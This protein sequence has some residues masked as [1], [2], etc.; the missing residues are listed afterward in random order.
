[1]IEV[2]ELSY[3]YSKAKTNTIDNLCFEV[4]KGEIFGFLGPSGSGKSTTQKILTG[5]MDNYEGSVLVNG[6]EIKKRKRFFY[7]NIG[8]SY[9][10]PNVY[11][12]LTGIENLQFVRHFYKNATQDPLELL[13]MVG[14]EEYAYRKV[15]QYS[16]G[17]KMRLN[18]ARAFINDPDLLFFDE[19][20]SGLDPNNSR[21]VKDIILQSKEK[22][23]TV[24]LTTHNMNIAEE[25]C[26]R[27]AFI[28]DGKI[29]LIDNPRQL[30]V[31]YGERKVIIEY[32]KANELNVREFDMEGLGRNKEFMDFI[33]SESQ[34]VTI[35]SKDASL[36]DVF[37]RV[38]GRKLT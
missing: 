30:K 5:I 15:S 12:K 28:V 26:D 11:N 16:K 37:N 23:K 4:K 1:M 17:M 7:E 38:T 25:L 21:V 24:F 34:I 27:V 10:F 2:C 29:R 32:M 3:K 22:G 31:M 18:F 14:L 33:K 8:V 35:H 20:T 36:E 13:K 19:P 6:V 9:E